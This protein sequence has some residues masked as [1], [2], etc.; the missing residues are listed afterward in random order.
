MKSTNM[1]LEGLLRQIKP[2]DFYAIANT[3]GD[4]EFKLKNRD[5]I[6]IAIDE[7]LR[8]AE[9]KLC[10][11][12]GKTYVY[13]GCYW[14][15]VEENMLK[16]FLGEAAA[17]QGI[18]KLASKHFNYREHLLKQFESAAYLPEPEE[19]PDKVLI[20]LQ[21]GTL[22]ISASEQTIKLR[23]FKASDFLKYQL[24]FIYDSS[25]KA[26]LFV[27]Y[28][29]HVLPDAESRKALL[30]YLGYL[31]IKH[32]S[33][34]L[35]LEKVLILLGT[36]ANG[37]SVLYEVM[38]SLLGKENLSHYSLAKLT[39]NAGNARAKFADK[40]LN[41]ATEIN[42][43]IGSDYFKAMASGEPVS[44]RLLYKDEITLTQYPKM[45]FNCNELPKEV[46][47]TNGFF[48][49]F[50][51][52]PFEVTIPKEEQDN[53]LS[54]KIVKSELSGVLNLIIHNLQD[55]LQRG[56]FPKCDAIEKARE[57]YQLES[58]SV[59]MFLHE[60]MYQP[61]KRCTLL[62]KKLFT[63]YTE[64]CRESGNKPLAKPRFSKRLQSL[65]YSKGQDRYG[66][67]Y[68]VE[69]KT[70]KV[71]TTGSPPSPPS[72]SEAD[73]EES[74]EREAIL[75]SFEFFEEI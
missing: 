20:N 65:G 32:S 69:E 25:A 15:E 38:E 4:K 56:Q 14:S 59:R 44:A 53:Q 45:I 12:N 26:P 28:L 16:S 31:F 49:R 72:H 70:S 75:Q 33:K 1:I 11:N 47:N 7:I 21:N 62:L 39:D 67:F 2:V 10:L 22:E 6:V 35:K 36:G 41:Y 40:I 27:D 19:D 58:D 60:T 51:I 74:E 54:N 71:F 55:L 23:E 48:R 34:R 37:K 66:V 5:V 24:T 13:N 46:E 17:R 61:S 29:Q 18:D 42:G 9:N 64:Y 68:F 63:D 52:I 50:M 73:R 57:E 30:E 43:A 3:K 8:L